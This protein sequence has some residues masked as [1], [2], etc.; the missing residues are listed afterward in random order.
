[1]TQKSVEKLMKAGY[2]FVRMRKGY[3]NNG[4]KIYNIEQSR[5]HSEWTVLDEFKRMKECLQALEELEN[6]RYIIVNQHNYTR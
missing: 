4:K 6:D 1:M 2:S 3:D 5:N